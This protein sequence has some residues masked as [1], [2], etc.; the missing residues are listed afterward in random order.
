MMT[1]NISILSIIL[2]LTFSQAQALPQ[3]NPVPGG[4]VFVELGLNSN[5]RPQVRYRNDPVML[6]HTETGWQAI[7][8][9]P[10]SGK[11]GKHYL[12][13]D[14][15]SKQTRQLS[16]M[17]KA[18]KYAEQRLTIK[19]K[20]M[21]NPTAKD[22]IRIRKEIKI[23]RK[24]FG[25]WDEDYAIPAPLLQPTEGI[26]SSSFGLRRF[27]NGQARRPHSGMDIA[28][29]EGQVVI[30]P[31]QGKVIAIGD[32]FFN[33]KTVFVDHGQGLISMF[34]HLND[35]HVKPGQTV[36]RGD[37]VANVGM[38][39]RV[40]GPHLHWSLSLNNTRIDPELFLQSR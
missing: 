39:G 36:K 4:I 40:T 38:T 24:A 17:V 8:G 27:F 35:I 31:A 22:M 33:G 25:S 10:L 29:P 13:I 34:C 26:R 23:I 3:Q 37:R 15:G 6:H 11:A 5:Q 20:R 30:T 14:E 1:N 9:I 32:Y 2:F 12:E 16:F 18:K 7:I 19:N 28:A 21:V